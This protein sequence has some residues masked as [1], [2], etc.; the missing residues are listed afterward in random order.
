MKQELAKL[1]KAFSDNVAAQTDAIWAGDARTGNKHAKRYLRAFERMRA[2]GDEGVTRWCRYC[3][4]VALPF[5]DRHASRDAILRAC[6]R[7]S[8][9]LGIGGPARI[10]AALI[11]NERGDSERAR[12][13]LARQ[14]RGRQHPG[15]SDYVRS[16]AERIGLG[17]LPIDV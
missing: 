6:A 12:A 9:A 10:V 2:I 1:V 8:R 17:P 14:A 11:L 5:F 7:N 16:L 4:R 15:H 3:R 13:L